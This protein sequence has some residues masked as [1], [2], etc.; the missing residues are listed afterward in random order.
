[1]S[2]P[3]R[4]PR[5]APPQVQGCTCNRLRRLTRRVTAVYDHAL[6]PCGL[7][8]TQFSLLSNLLA[9]Q[10]PTLSV[11]AEAMDMER[12]TL[13]RNLRP[14]ITAGWVALR[15]GRN[16]RHR[17]ARMTPAGRAKWAQAKPHW[18]RAQSALTAVLGDAEVSRLH[19]L[20]DRCLPLLRSPVHPDG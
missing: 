12:T 20:V 18:R 6:A 2:S 3:S 8:G 10:A 9:L 15:P 14:L 16:A 4:R 1:M 19:R 13:T 11:L 7:R 17:E 5:D